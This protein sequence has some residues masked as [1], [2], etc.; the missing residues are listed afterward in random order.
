M[1]NVLLALIMLT[2]L[3]GSPVWVETSAVTIIR[4]AVT[5][6]KAD[7]GAA[8][9][10]GSQAICVRETPEQIKKKVEGVR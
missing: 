6:C 5:Q 2:S 10:I 1:R 3:D 7:H 4:P 9:R 8:I